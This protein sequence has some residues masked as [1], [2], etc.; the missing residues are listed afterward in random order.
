[1]GNIIKLQSS[2]LKTELIR[3]QSDGSLGIDNIK[4]IVTVVTTFF[5]DLLNV[6]KSRNYFDLLP[7]VFNL[8]R[9]GNIIA[10]AGL[11]WEE[12]KDTSLA[13]S[14]DI[15]Q[16]FVGVFNIPDDKTE[17][18]IERAF[19]VIPK[20]YELFVSGTV[21]VSDAKSVWSEIQ[22]IVKGEDLPEVLAIAA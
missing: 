21:L 13:E 5:V 11:A 19:G 14:N 7:L 20:V 22:S 3:A 16:H 6:I 9:Q 10:I 18:L 8:I 1:M 4:T 12:I 17:Q 15:H 2:H